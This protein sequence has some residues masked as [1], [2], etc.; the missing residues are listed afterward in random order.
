ME[1][2]VRKQRWYK[3]CLGYMTIGTNRESLN[4]VASARTK[5]TINIQCSLYTRH[6]NI[7]ISSTQPMGGKIMWHIS[8]ISQQQRWTGQEAEASCMNKE[9]SPRENWLERFLACVR[10]DVKKQKLFQN[11][12][13]WIFTSPWLVAD[14]AGSFVVGSRRWRGR[15]SWFATR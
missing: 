14:P 10:R 3:I 5:N 1:H 9:C 15:W 11:V 8:R 6:E 2:W 7:L 12:P 13:S 4:P